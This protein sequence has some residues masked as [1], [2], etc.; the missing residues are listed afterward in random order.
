MNAPYEC[1]PT[2]TLLGSVHTRRT[3][4]S[5]AALAPATSCS[6]YVSLGSTPSA[7]EPIM[8]RDGPSRMARVSAR[9]PHQP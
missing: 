4:S 8:G 1:P 2:A 5:T 7:A 3:T 9:E 6:M